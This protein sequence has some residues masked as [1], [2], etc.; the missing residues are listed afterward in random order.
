[1]MIKMMMLFMK[2]IMII[3]LLLMM[4]VMMIMMM[5]MTT[6]Q[7]IYM[8]RT[9]QSMFLGSLRITSLDHLRDMRVYLSDIPLYDITRE[10]VM[11]N[12]QRIAEIDLA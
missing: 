2:I 9:R 8:P 7:M 11:L 10:L 5:I 1:M 4:I 3:Q 6:G 12:Q